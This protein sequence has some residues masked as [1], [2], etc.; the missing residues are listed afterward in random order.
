MLDTL[1][2]MTPNAQR[3]IAVLILLVT[4]VFSLPLVAAVL[5]GPRT[6]NW[7]IPVQLIV[8]AAIG[9]GVALA[10]PAV[11]R[12]GAS[13]AARAVTGIGWGLLAAVVGL[14]VFWFLLNG[15]GGA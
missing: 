15:F 9:A 14:L 12:D 6:E 7:I 1:R 13:T 8:M 10:F 3:T 11:A 2:R 5:D 4:G